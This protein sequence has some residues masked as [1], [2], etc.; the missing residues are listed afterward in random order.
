MRNKCKILIAKP[1][2][3][4]RL[5][6]DGSI[7][8]KWS[9]KSKVWCCGLFSAGLGCTTVSISSEHSIEPLDFIK[10]E[11]F[12]GGLLSTLLN[13]TYLAETASLSNH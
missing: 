3:V 10:S 6:V 13:L 9:L 8:L 2:G 11:N 1:E 12:D 5:G 7:I 4:T